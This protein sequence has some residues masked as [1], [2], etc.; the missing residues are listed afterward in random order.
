MKDKNGDILAVDNYVYHI[1]NHAKGDVTHNS[2]ELGQI[3]NISKNFIFVRFKG[4]S[5]SLGCK[6]ENIQLTDGPT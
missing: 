4:K 5:Q 1:P 2:S 3:I 6:R